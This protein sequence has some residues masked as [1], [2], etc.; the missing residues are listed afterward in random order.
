VT[1]CRL[2]VAD[3]GPDSGWEV[4]W[5][6]GVGVAGEV[7]IV[8]SFRQ[9]VQRSAFSVQNTTFGV[10]AAMKKPRAGEAFAVSDLQDLRGTSFY[11]PLLSEY[12][13]QLKNRPNIFEGIRV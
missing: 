2:Q 3:C 6:V 5:P 12:Q 11:Y 4:V 7:D 9:S 1:G 8:V 10:R 13:V